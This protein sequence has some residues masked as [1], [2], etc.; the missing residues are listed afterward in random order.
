MQ[1]REF[2][3]GL[4]STVAWPVVAA[5]QQRQQMRRIGVFMAAAADDADTQFRIAGL[6][7]G[8]Q[9]LGW[10]VGLNLRIDWR[11]A[12]ADRERY[13]ALAA[14]LLALNPDVVLAGGATV[15]TMQ[16]VTRT[17]PIV[18][19]GLGDPVGGGYVASLARPGT[20]R[21]L[22]RP[23]TAR[24]G[25]GWNCLSRSR[26]ASRVWLSF[27]IP[28][29]PAGWVNMRRFRPCQGPSGWN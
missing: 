19:A 29:R 10:T 13:P 16:Q 4:G 26:L 2:I 27:A 8:L 24:V 15:R 5:A 1:R 3:A 17:V 18:F 14:E 25:N 22:H 20:S 7:Q 6:L 28:S 21:A 23:N 12:T 9:E 11:W